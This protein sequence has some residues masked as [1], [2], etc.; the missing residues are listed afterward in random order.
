MRAGTTTSSELFSAGFRLD[1]SYHANEGSKAFRHLNHWTD[2]DPRLHRL[3][4]VG[5][6]CLIN[7]LFIGGRAKRIYVDDSAHGIPFLSSSDM[8]LA[9]FDGVKLI[10]NKQPELESLLLRRGWT[11]ISRSGTIGNTTYVRDDMD[12]LAGSEHIMRVVADPQKITPGYLYTFLSSNIGVSLIRQGTFGAV[13]DTIAPEYIASLP[14][15]RL[16]ME[17]EQH[18]HELIEQAA[19]LRVQAN[20]KKQQAEI[21]TSQLLSVELN[22][23][24]ARKLRTSIS[25]GSLNDRLE[26][27]YHVAQEAAASLRNSPFPMI[28]LGHLLERIFYLGKLHRVFVNDSKSGVPLLSISDAQKAKLTSD[29]FISKTLSRNIQDAMLESGWIL[30]S[31]VGTPGL[32]IYT[33]REMES[34]AG[35]DHLVRL[36]PNRNQLL[37][38]YLFSLLSSPMGKEVLVGSAHGSVQLVLP[39]E[40]IEQIQIPLPPIRLQIEIHN[41]I[42]QYGE[43]LT[44]AS[45]LEDQ[46]QALLTRSLGVGYAN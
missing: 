19:R 39:P 32:V 38:G 34:L 2:Q 24:T 25:V 5:N 41:L 30:V 15:P 18:I 9:S 14:I 29:K 37:P 40:Y 22:I 45:E 11:L 33:R 4:R 21:I 36:V 31:R 17:Q 20:H 7:G 46:A 16:S 23:N 28:P 27:N 10:S 44:K 3:D 12:G 43:E 13:V 6:V 1:A 26:A 42:E 35:T 8:L